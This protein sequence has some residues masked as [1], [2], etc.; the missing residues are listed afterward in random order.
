MASGKKPRNS[1]VNAFQDINEKQGNY[2]PGF[3][4]GWLTFKE[5]QAEHKIGHNKLRNMIQIGVEDGS[6]EAFEG[7]APN[8]TGRLCR[9]VWYRII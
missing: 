9:S 2:P 5:L 4:K 6:I 3:P 7:T 1:W 8:I